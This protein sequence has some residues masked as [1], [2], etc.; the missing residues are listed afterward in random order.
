MLLSGKTVAPGEYMLSLE[1][2]DIDINNPQ[3]WSG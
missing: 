1:A 3:Y 2:T